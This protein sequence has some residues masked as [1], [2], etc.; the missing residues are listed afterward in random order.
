MRNAQ[1]VTIRKAS[2]AIGVGLIEEALEREG[3]KGC[4][5]FLCSSPVSLEPP[6]RRFDSSSIL[7][8]SSELEMSGVLGDGPVEPVEYSTYDI[9]PSEEDLLGIEWMETMLRALSVLPGPFAFEL[10]GSRGCVW[11]RFA[12]PTD[13]VPGLRA[14]LLGHFPALRLRLVDRPFPSELPAA[15]NEL[16][17]VSPYHRSLTLLGREGA[18]PLAIAASVISGLAEDECGV[19]QVLFSPASPAHDWHYNVGNMVEAEDRASRLALLGGL[20]SRFSYDSE[21]PPLAEPSVREKV[22]VDVAFY[23]VVVRYAVW[24]AEPAVAAAFLQG[25]RVASARWSRPSTR[26]PR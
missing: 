11:V 3:R 1:A 14:A 22:R 8:P 7:S 26:V 23:A 2:T 18:S 16:V 12:V 4:S 20:S 24:T 6:F 15:V 9:Y 19:F 21:L 5:P 10:L 25:M 17:P 13:Q